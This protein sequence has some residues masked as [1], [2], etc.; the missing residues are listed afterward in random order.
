MTEKISPWLRRD[1]RSIFGNMCIGATHTESTNQPT[2]RPTIQPPA[3]GMRRVQI[4]DHACANFHPFPGIVNSSPLPLS[5]FPGPLPPSH[6]FPLLPRCS[7]SLLHLSPTTT[8]SACTGA[9]LP[10]PRIFRDS[11]R[12]ESIPLPRQVE[13]VGMATVGVQRVQSSVL[14]LSLVSLVTAPHKGIAL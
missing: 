4:A 6:P 3:V 12:P 2:N 8:A 5:T 7:R 9:N 10:Q 13:T 1:A 14:G 11:F